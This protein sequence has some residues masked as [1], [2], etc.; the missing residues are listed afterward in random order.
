MNITEAMA[1]RT[2]IRDYLDKEI[3]RTDIL[4]LFKAGMTAP[5]ARNIQP[6]HFMAI[7]TDSVLESLSDA[8]PN[9]PML[10]RAPLGI[11]VAA[12]QY[13]AEA[14]TPGADFWIQDCS[15]A[16]ENILLAALDLGLGAVWLGVHPVKERIEAVKRILGLPDHI[17][18]LSLIAVGHPAREAKPKDK[19]RED[20]LHWEKW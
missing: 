10:G 18:P 20:R 7:T 16:T 8:L 14:G 6:W 3:T 5:S 15:A 13:E 19:F 11:L 4:R 17:A 12:D 9:A 2:S 1:A